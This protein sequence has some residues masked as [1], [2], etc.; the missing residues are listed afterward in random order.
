M[1]FFCAVLLSLCAFMS[2][3]PAEITSIRT[4]Q[5][6]VPYLEQADDRTLVVFDI[7]MVV[8]QPDEPAFQMANMK[9]HKAIAKKVSGTIP[10]LQEV[11]INLMLV[12]S[13]SV[14]IDEKTPGLIRGLA[15]KGV[16]TMALTANLT[17]S[18]VHVSKME[19]LKIA[20]LAG[21][22]IDFAKGAPYAGEII[23][24][25]LPS[26]RGN[27]CL[28]KSGIFFVNGSGKL[29]GEALV[30]FMKKTGFVPKKVLFIDDREDNV[31]ILETALKAF[32]PEIQYQGVIFHGAGEYP[33]KIISEKEFEEKWQE[34]AD[35]AIK[36][37]DPHV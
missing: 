23:F 30:S 17:G 3:S 6:F 7:D 2:K 1:K 13:E 21:L 31:Q 16:P 36:L 14:L 22:G 28:Y 35:I 12:Y 8:V 11:F 29:K 10:G 9:R 18:L 24:T 19:D 27:Y 15:E 4:M 37:G 20:R 32:N 25:D 33:S 26:F 5:E 34:L